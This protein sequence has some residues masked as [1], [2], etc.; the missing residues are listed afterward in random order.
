VEIWRQYA[1]LNAAAALVS[2][3]LLPGCVLPIPHGPAD[4]FETRHN[5]GT[6][7]PSFVVPGR[8]TR[9]DVLLT[10][11]EA[12]AVASDESWMRF[13]AGYRTGGVLVF[14]YP[15]PLIP[16]YDTVELRQVTIHFDTSGIVER[17]DF[18]RL[19]C[20]ITDVIT[21]GASATSHRCV[22]AEGKEVRAGPGR[23]PAR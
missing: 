10:L 6:E 4:D 16:S 1:W 2:L 17:A 14:A 9:E 3:L 11:G 22:D 7:V 5:V 12:D 20:R 21:Q 13:Q 15:S 8:T 18:E 23:L 19:T